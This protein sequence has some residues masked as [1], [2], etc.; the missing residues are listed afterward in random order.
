MINQDNSDD[1][2][3]NTNYVLNSDEEIIDD[4]EN[5]NYNE[6]NFEYKEIDKNDLGKT[7]S[8]NDFNGYNY[9]CNL[10][11]DKHCIYCNKYFYED[12]FINNCEYCIHCWGWLNNQQINLKEGKYTGDLDYTDLKIKLKNTYKFHKNCNNED[13][14]FNKIEKAIKDNTLHIE[15]CKLL[16]VNLE[17]NTIKKVYKINNRKKLKINYNLS[18]IS[19]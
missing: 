4:D 17:E 19:I 18:Q 12:M 9:S 15:F 11:N 13:C 3:N 5:Y 2:L 1:Y 14:I 8:S 7:N 10:G 6:E 16:N